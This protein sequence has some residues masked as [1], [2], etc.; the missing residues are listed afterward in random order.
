MT[1]NMYGEEMSPAEFAEMATGLL[2]RFASATN[3]RI[4][5]HKS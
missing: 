5:L 2:E 3:I 1:V 4:T